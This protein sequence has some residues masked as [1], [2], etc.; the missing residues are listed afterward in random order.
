MEDGNIQLKARNISLGSLQ[1]PI[2]YVMKQLEHVLDIPKWVEFN[3]EET[4]IIVHLDQ[5]PLKN[6]LRLKADRINLVDD[7]IRMSVYLPIENK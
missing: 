1:L 4:Y 6:G 7:D 2:S 5:L 3:S